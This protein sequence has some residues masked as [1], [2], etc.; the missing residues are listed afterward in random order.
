MI[1]K[2][3]VVASFA[4]GLANIEQ[5]KPMTADTPILVGSIS[6]TI[7]GTALAL[8]TVNPDAALPA[9]LF[10]IDWPT[11]GPTALSWRQL[12]QHQSGIVD[13]ELAL[14]CN[15]YLL[16]DGSSLFNLLQPED[17][18]CPAPLTGQQQFLQSLCIQKMVSGIKPTT[19][20][21]LAKRNTATLALPYSVRRLPAKPALR[22]QLGQHNKF[23][24]RC[25]CT[26]L[27]GQ[28]QQRALLL[29]PLCISLTA[30]AS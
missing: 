26:I 13:Q 12:A 18:A 7:L 5:Q 16:E 30:R 11:T 8:T 17:P 24:T 14:V 27:F 28:P 19:L 21:P 10:A 3:K 1:R 4:H 23:L 29:P 9:L 20:A 15:I 25:N 6:K 22:W 2:G